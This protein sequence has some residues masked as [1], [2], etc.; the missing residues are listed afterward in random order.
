[1]GRGVFVGIFAVAAGISV[2]VINIL[3]DIIQPLRSVVIKITPSK[4][5][6]FCVF[7]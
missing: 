1:V 7:I 3:F 2:G 6:L 5:A 4:M